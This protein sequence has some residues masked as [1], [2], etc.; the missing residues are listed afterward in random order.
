MA[1]LLCCCDKA[2]NKYAPVDVHYSNLPEADATLELS[3]SHSI[4][5]P[6]HNG[7]FPTGSFLIKTG[8]TALQ[9]VPREAALDPNMISGN[10]SNHCGGYTC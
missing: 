10:T 8:G 7:S 6:S 9:E 4:D 3:R 1:D 2:S 5:C